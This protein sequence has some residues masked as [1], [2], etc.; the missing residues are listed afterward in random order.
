MQEIIIVRT[1]GEQNKGAGFGRIHLTTY[2]L[3]RYLFSALLRPPCS[4]DFPMYFEKLFEYFCAFRLAW[5]KNL[6]F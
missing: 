1:S 3:K 5:R 4:K 6:L 2:S